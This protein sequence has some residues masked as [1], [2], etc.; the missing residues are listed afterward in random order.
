MA[1]WLIL[2]VGIVY[3]FVSIKLFLEGNTGLAIAFL[4]YAFSNVGLYMV[5]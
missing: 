1:G 5:A 2:G 3:F 4:G